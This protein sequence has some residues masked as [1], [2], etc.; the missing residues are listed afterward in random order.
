MSYYLIDPLSDPRWNSFIERHSSSSIFHTS[1]WLLALKSTYRFEPVAI[2]TS[3]PGQELSNSIA[4]C[5][6]ESWLTGRRL[7][8]LPFSD[9]C[10]PLADS[11]GGLELLFEG[12]R[13]I[14]GRDQWSYI[15]LRPKA[16]IFQDKRIPSGFAYS[17]AYCFHELDLR[18]SLER[19]SSSFHKDCVLRKIRRA[20]RDGLSYEAGRS[21]EM[22]H[23]FYA[24]QVLT[25]RRQK[26]PPQPYRWFKNLL[27]C[28][29]EKLTI[30]VAS[31]EGRA[32][33]SLITINHGKTVV[34]KYGCSD[35]RYSSHGGTQLLFW[36]VIQ[37]AKEMGFESL[38]L[39]RS[40]CENQGLIDFKTRWG[41]ARTELKYLRNPAVNAS[42]SSDWKFVL[43]RKLAAFVP[44]LPLSW[45]GTLLYRHFA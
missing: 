44:G 24:L 18:P 29:G 7:L 20:E 17:K 40:D 30:W 4:F 2:T 41:S 39:G 10:D 36:R 8:S 23:K 14:Q 22:L 16:P 5:R 3:P 35:D 33:A 45:A 37:Q 28:F 21:E 27:Q 26:V 11:P 1:G 42:E 43:A 15:E 6:V 9:H 38:D 31:F 32:I 12:L 34:Y 13:E 19:L 25:R